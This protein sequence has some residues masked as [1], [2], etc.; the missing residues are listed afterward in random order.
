MRILWL[1]SDLLLPLD[2]GGRLRTWHLMRHLARRHDI[3]YLSFA[4]GVADGMDRGRAAGRN[5]AAQP[6]RR[7]ARCAST[8]TRPCTSSIRCRMPSRSTDRAAF[9]RRLRDL[10]AQDRYDLVVCDFLFPAVNLPRHAPLPGGHLHPQR[11]SGD[12]AA[13]CRDPNRSG[14]VALSDAAPP[15]APLRAARPGA[16]RRRARGVRRRSEDVRA[17]V[18]R[19]D[20]ARTCTSCRPASIPSSSRPRR[21]RRADAA[22]S[23]RARWTGCPTRTR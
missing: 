1:K 13:A 15:D 14:A 8:P 10:L 11:R 19:R 5:G 20:P 22:W 9:A 12:L 4:E 18:S 2:K 16:V 3:T 17:A 6:S 21:P 23:S 7:R